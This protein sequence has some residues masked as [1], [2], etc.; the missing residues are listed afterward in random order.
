[1]RGEG[2]LTGLDF[3][4]GGDIDFVGRGVVCSEE[5]AGF[6]SSKLCCCRS[7]GVISFCGGEE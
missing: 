2:G 6:A 3:V 1:M 4:V 7:A 5:V